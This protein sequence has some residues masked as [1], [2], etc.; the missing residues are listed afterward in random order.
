MA[1]NCKVCKAKSDANLCWPCTNDL[2]QLLMGS[3]EQGTGHNG[4]GW[5]SS[6]LRETVYRQ[7]RLGNSAGRPTVLH[8]YSQLPN[9][10]ARDLLHRIRST[11]L[12][13]LV[14]SMSYIDSQKLSKSEQAVSFG[15][16]LARLTE[17]EIAAMLV[18][19]MRTLRAVEGIELLHAVLLRL[20]KEAWRVINRPAETCCGPCPDCST[21]LYSHPED[22]S[23][24]CPHCKETYVV[25][26]L[27]RMMREHISDMLFTGPELRKLC[28]T[29][30]N[31]PI[32]KSTF[33]ALISD[34]RLVPR[35]RREDGTSF[36]T[37]DD[38]QHA[39]S[40]PKRKGKA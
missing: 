24:V 4:I 38:L 12:A 32:P 17:G 26:D 5:Y 1:S 30:L 22:A 16:T 34:Q 29:R 6:R 7:D 33:Y 2:R 37:Y 11:L 28:E 3:D 25:E 18:G 39:R 36:F 35:Y 20:S 27:R 14:D 15:R 40:K 9:E 23:V 10:P 31:D 13:W 8:G 19:R 21:V